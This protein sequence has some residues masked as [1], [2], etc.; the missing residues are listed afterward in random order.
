MRSFSKRKLEW[1]TELIKEK[2]QNRINPKLYNFLE[3][4]YELNG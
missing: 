2:D 4:F 1:M 3:A